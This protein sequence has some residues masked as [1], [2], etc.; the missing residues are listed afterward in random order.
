MR[1][2]GFRGAFVVAFLN[3]K[4]ISMKEALDLQTK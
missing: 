1:G 3:D 2:N 4:R